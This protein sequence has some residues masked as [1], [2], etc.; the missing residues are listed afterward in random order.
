M[1]H[2]YIDEEVHAYDQALDELRRVDHLVYV[3]LKYTRTVDVL[4]NTLARMIDCFQCV[5][6][7]LLK[8]AEDQGMVF[9][10]PSAPGAKVTEL[11][12]LYPNNKELNDLISFYL[13][14]RKLHN[15][16]YTAAREFRR[17]VTMTATF[18]DG[19]VEEVNI[20]IISDYYERCKKLITGV[21][22]FFTELPR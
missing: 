4:K 13:F 19:G 12:K 3:S 14:L 15:A 21:K 22:H 8:G 20:D 1:N 9:E 11:R 6:D 5:I 7:G 16:E 18:P 10:I 2:R 17:N